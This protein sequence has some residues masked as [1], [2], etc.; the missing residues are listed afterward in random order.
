[1]IKL[2]S[3]NKLLNIVIMI[4]YLARSSIK[5][6]SYLISTHPSTMINIVNQIQASII[7]E[8]NVD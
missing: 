2:S 8:A 5:R 3:F 1:M 6:V 4:S 7:G